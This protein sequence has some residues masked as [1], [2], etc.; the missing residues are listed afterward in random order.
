[1]P[2]TLTHAAK[3]AEIRDLLPTSMGTAQIREKFAEQ[4]MARSVFSARVANA[5]FLTVLKEVI[6]QLAEGNINEA[7]ARLA[8]A[9]ILR[10]LG[11]TPEGGFP[12][13][14]PGS[15]PPA[16]QGSLQDLLSFKRLQLIVDTQRGLMQGA[17][18]Q[19]RGS[20]PDRLSQF[21]AWELVRQIS[22]RVPRD[23]PSRWVIA[24]GSFVDGGRMIALK[25]DPIWGELGSYNNFDDA[26]GVDFPPFAFNSGMGWEEVP[27]REVQALGITG[28]DGESAADWLQS[29]PHTLAGEQPLPAPILSVKDIDPA[30]LNQLEK[31]TGAVIKDD[32]A[33]T[34]D[35][36][37]ELDRRAAEREVRRKARLEQGIKDAKQA[38]AGRAA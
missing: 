33:T 27:A 2:A 38:Y 13:D 12:T 34:P 6:N 11:Y 1:M 28:P 9:E 26:L 20:D 18:Q 25:G 32:M 5:D 37:A 21:P 24:G 31:E 23:W 30:L 4:I 35:G 14:L 15:V 19:Q 7:S 16:V 22:V 17:G 29:K 8:L 3:V 10:A 36:A